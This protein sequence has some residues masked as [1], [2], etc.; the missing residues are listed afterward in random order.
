MGA[1][2]RHVYKHPGNS[3]SG[4]DTGDDGVYVQY[5]ALYDRAFRRRAEVTKD[6]N[7]SVVNTSLF[8]LRFGDRARRRDICQVC[9]SESH[10]SERCP[11]RV[12]ALGGTHTWRP[13]RERPRTLSHRQWQYSIRRSQRHGNRWE[14][15]G[16]AKRSCAGCSTAGAAI[17]AA[18]LAASLHTAALNAVCQGTEQRNAQQHWPAS[19]GWLGRA[20]SDQGC[21]DEREDGGQS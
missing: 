5:C 1:V 12:L 14:A 21:R 16:E 3:A 9:L 10:G 19:Q 13:S 7:W 4:E 20:R 2:L 17:A 6:L 11:R 15:T 18:S 8:N